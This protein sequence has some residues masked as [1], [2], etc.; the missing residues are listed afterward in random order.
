MWRSVPAD[1]RGLDPDEKLAGPGVGTGTSSSTSPGPECR[2]RTARMVAPDTWRSCHAGAG[3]RGQSTRSD[4][5]VKGERQMQRRDLA[6]GA[7]CPG[8]DPVAPGTIGDDPPELKDPLGARVIIVPDESSRA[9]PGRTLRSDTVHRTPFRF[10]STS[11]STSSAPSSGL[12]F[13]F[14]VLAFADP[15]P[16]RHRPSRSSPAPEP[17]RAHKLP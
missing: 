14:D 3:H 4:A 2:F 6:R 1:A 10:W 13:S 15:E 8:T 17:A 9:P 5:S 16:G 7:R 11:N 12:S